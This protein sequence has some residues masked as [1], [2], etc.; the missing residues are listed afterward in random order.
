VSGLKT[1]QL[2]QTIER[3]G[4]KNLKIYLFIVTSKYARALL[5][6]NVFLVIL[7]YLVLLVRC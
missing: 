2:S 7:F 1:G 4:R 5:R 6:V 3:V